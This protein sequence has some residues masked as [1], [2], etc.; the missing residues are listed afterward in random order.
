M[1]RPGSRNVGAGWKAP[2]EREVEQGF[3]LVLVLRLPVRA[4]WTES[5]QRLVEKV[6]ADG[7]LHALAAMEADGVTS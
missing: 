6:V 7:A 4:K 3:H 2:T 5:Q 1:Q